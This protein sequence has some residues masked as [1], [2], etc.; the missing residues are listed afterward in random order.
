MKINRHYVTSPSEIVTIEMGVPYEYR[1]KCIEEIYN[2][3]D[4]M[5]NTTNVKAIMTS[6]YL[7]DH[8]D[9]FNPL[10]NFI[11][12]IVTKLGYFNDN[13]SYKLDNAWGSIYKSNT[14]AVPH[15]HL[16]QL[17]SFVYYLK[18]TNESSQ[19][20]FNQ[21][22]FTLQPKEDLLV[23]FPAHLVHSVPNQEHNNRAIIAG[24]YRAI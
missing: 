20:V 13:F 22:N 14:G 17:V 3:G 24:N 18:Y 21:A 2:I 7:W 23:V 6:Y 1:Q 11:T 15:N 5:N 4:H 8:S 12:K 9:F 16:P 19:L 10:L